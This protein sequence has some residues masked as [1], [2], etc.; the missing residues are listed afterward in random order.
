MD[1]TIV[2]LPLQKMEKNKKHNKGKKQKIG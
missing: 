2:I 1:Y